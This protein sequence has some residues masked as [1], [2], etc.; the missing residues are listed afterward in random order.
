VCRNLLQDSQAVDTVY[1]FV[2]GQSPPR[3]DMAAAP[4]VGI[5]AADGGAEHALALGLPVDLVVGDFDS[6][7]PETLETLGRAGTR[8]ERHPAAKDKTDLELAPDAA[9][10]L[11]PR[12]VVV[13]GGDGGRL[14]H[15]LGGL[16][17][18]AADAY[19]GVEIDALVGPA[20]VHVV[21]GSRVLSGTPG[22]TISLLAVGGPAVGVVT[23]GL[24]Y[25]LRGEALVVGTSRGVSNAFAAA[26][27]R[28]RA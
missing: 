15:L 19:V 22:E 12:R 21:R 6:I 18:L 26:E 14:D 23:D 5:V 11:A 9:L 3:L 16:L 17:V 7:S 10:T 20:T 2:G 24:V 28:I 4:G 1:V 27:A 8:V 25:P 13:V